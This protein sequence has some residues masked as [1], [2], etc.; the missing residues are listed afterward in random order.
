[1]FCYAANRVRMKSME[2]KQISYKVIENNQK[3]L[4]KSVSCVHSSTPLSFRL[5]NWLLHRYCCLHDA[6]SSQNYKWMNKNWINK[7]K[8]IYTKFTYKDTIIATKFIILRSLPVLL[9]V[10]EVVHGIDFSTTISLL[11]RISDFF[12]VLNTA[13]NTLAYFGKT[14]WLENKLR[15]RL[16]KRSKTSN[17]EV[18]QYLYA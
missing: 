1:M 5:M 11:V 8:H 13:T 9:D 6:Y 4:P 7:S 3:N 12:V 16:L 14:G 10:Y 18:S 2:P 17:A 15:G